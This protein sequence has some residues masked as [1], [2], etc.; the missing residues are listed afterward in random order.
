VGGKD[1]YLL[2]TN[3]AVIPCA[4]MYFYMTVM[5]I[6][7]SF[8]Y[9]QFLIKVWTLRCVSKTGQYEYVCSDNTAGNISKYCAANDFDQSL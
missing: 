4:S 8:R 5:T 1:S 9:E 6:S 2:H 3:I 7:L